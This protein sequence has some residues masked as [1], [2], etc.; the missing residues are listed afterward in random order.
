MFSIVKNGADELNIK[1][2][3]EA[4]TAFKVYYDFL[5]EQS[6]NINLTTITGEEDV[7]RLHFLDSVALLNAVD[8]K[9][10]KVIDIGSGAGFPGLPIKIAEPSVNLS[11]LDATG[12]KTLFLSDLCKKLE[13]DAL[14]IN[15]RA[16]EAAHKPEFREK[17]NIVV[18]RAVARLSILCE[19]CLPFVKVDGVFIAMKSIDSEDEVTEAAGAVKTLG[20]TAIKQ[21]DYKI[22]GTDIIHRAVIISKKIESP[23]KY[24]RR[25][26]KIQKSPL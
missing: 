18:S 13:L 5:E 21:Y 24:P 1:L 26:A 22:P 3:P 11:L 2:P 25:Y 20:A 19:L 6:Q 17:Y 8:F 4:E 7:S 16:E 12:K 15:A 23:E 14:C 10:K 9:G